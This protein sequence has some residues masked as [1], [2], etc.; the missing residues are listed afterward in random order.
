[1]FVPS[2]DPHALKQIK[3]RKHLPFLLMKMYRVIHIF[4]KK[5]QRIFTSQPGRVASIY[6]PLFSILS[7]TVFR[8]VFIIVT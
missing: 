3:P 2:I 8:E 6:L 5:A 4:A 1:M 7:V